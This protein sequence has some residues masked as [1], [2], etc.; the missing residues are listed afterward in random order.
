MPLLV[1]TAITDTN[2][3]GQIRRVR[4]LPCYR[5]PSN[6]DDLN[7]L[8]LLQALSVIGYQEKACCIMSST[9]WRRLQKPMDSNLAKDGQ[10]VRKPT[11]TD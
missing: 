6:Q 3:K 1:N 5:K 2:R 9:P 11:P 8:L 4:V 7:G 10:A